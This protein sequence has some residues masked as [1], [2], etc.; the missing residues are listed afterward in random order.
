MRRRVV[1][2]LAIL[3]AAGAPEAASQVRGFPLYA[4]QVPRG[5]TLG[6]DVAFP[7][8]DYCPG[9]CA[10]GT[11]AMGF[12]RVGVSAT[13]ATSGFGGLVTVTLVRPERSPFSLVIQ[14]GAS[15]TTGGGV[16][17]APFG[18][19]FSVWIPTPVVSLQPWIGFRG[20]YMYPGNGWEGD[21]AV[22]AGF[23]AGLSVTLLNGL[24][25]R[26]AYDRVLLTGNDLTTFGV[27]V[28]FSFDTGL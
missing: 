15:G 20:Q 28:F 6:A 14:G 21:G 3:L 5:I 7:S 25:V 11:A 1:P 4:V 26:A 17:Q 27:G 13:V 16:F 19:G 9:A 24:G 23:S 22:H 12:G 8:D 18:A 2:L 10:G